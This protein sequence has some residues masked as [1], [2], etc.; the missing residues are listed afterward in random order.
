MF[1]C[2]CLGSWRR[3][4]WTRGRFNAGWRPRIGTSRDPTGNV[5]CHS[6][7]LRSGFDERVGR[8][9]GPRPTP[10]PALQ[11]PRL[12]SG[13]LSPCIVSAFFLA[14]SPAGWSRSSNAWDLFRWCRPRCRSEYPRTCY[15]VVLTCTGPSV[16][17][18]RRP[19]VGVATADL[20]PSSLSRERSVC[21]PQR[22][23][24]LFDLESR[25]WSIGPS[26]RWPLFEGGRIRANIEASGAHEE[27]AL[28]EYSKAVLTSLEEAGERADRLLPGGRHAAGSS[29]SPSRRTGVRPS[30]PISCT[31]RG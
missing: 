11:V 18:H 27:Q 7:S 3:T 17:W 19:R 16:G 8:G 20:F 24:D 4:A 21:S 5:R 25:F 10:D 15:A 28:L 14:G 31:G 6:L 29:L 22:V 12:G 30:W 1:S 2:P 13:S 26:V 23:G 9:P